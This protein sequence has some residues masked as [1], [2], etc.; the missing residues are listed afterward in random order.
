MKYDKRVQCGL[1]RWRCG[2][3]NLAHVT[4]TKKY[5]IETKTTTKRQYPASSAESRIREG[6]PNGTGKDL[7]NRW[8][9]KSGCH[10]ELLFVSIV[11]SSHQHYWCL[12]SWITLR[13]L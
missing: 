13:M 6:S 2:E 7:W 1:K 8:V 9:F 3:L 12:S 4:E 10:H 11:V 5:K